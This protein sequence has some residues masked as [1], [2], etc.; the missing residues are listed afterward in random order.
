MPDVPIL[1]VPECILQLISLDKWETLL[2]M[3]GPQH[4]TT[5]K[6]HA[7]CLAWLRKAMLWPGDRYLQ[8]MA[9]YV[10]ACVSQP[11]HALDEQSVLFL[12]DMLRESSQSLWVDSALKDAEAEVQY[13]HMEQAFEGLKVLALSFG[14]SAVGSKSVARSGE[15]LIN[16]LRAAHHVR[17][18][19]RIHDLQ[20]VMLNFMPAALQE[21]GR[22]VTRKAPAGAT[23]SR[24]QAG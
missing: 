1:F 5:A 23:I 12:L 3:L 18:R 20:D 11:C 17:N 15:D 6:T 13:L 21:L 10:G 8:Q 4:S 14:C 24:H 2:L 16:A 19:S 9:P 22:S 7:A